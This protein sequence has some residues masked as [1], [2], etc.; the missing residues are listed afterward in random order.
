MGSEYAT[1][2]SKQ[3][4]RIGGS[5][6]GNADRTGKKGA[7]GL[8]GFTIGSAA[9]DA[10]FAHVVIAH[11]AVFVSVD[12]RLA[13]EHPFPTA[14]EDGVDAILY[15]IQHAEEL[16]INPHN[17][18][19]NGFSAG[20]NLAFSVPLKLNDWIARPHTGL[21][22]EGPHKT[23][24]H[25]SP[26]RASFNIRAVMAWY[27]S[28][29]FTVPRA[30]RKATNPRQDKELP[31]VLT[32]LFDTAYCSTGESGSPYLSPA[33]APTHLLKA[34]PDVIVLYPCQWDGLAAEAEKFK[35][36]LEH[37]TDKM[38]RYRV[39]P[40]ARHGFDRAPNPF[41][42]NA[43]RATYYQLACEELRAIFAS[44]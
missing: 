35:D 17:M 20:G 18:V 9:D 34:L 38:V 13:P 3:K 39:I 27:P 1:G 31:D 21:N 43:K 15:L 7:K 26:G 12:Y 11:D 6:D 2:V 37:E 22:L 5:F 14:V 19:V 33:A 23:K 8:G 10:R 41:Y 24:H 4:D 44:Q 25:V 42:S 32:N 16:G 40:E 36:R 30:V 28:L 29:D